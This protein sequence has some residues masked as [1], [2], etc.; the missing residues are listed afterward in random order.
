MKPNLAIFGGQKLQFWS[1][2][3]PLIM[4]FG[5]NATLESVKAA[6]FHTQL[7]C[8]FVTQPELS[9]VLWRK[10]K[11]ILGEKSAWFDLGSISGLPSGRSPFLPLYHPVST[12]V[13][14]IYEIRLHSFAKVC[15]LLQN[16]ANYFLCC[17]L[18]Y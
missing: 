12:K 16:I 1:F 10:T 14:K 17:T 7:L 11:T 18:E 13:C 8:F 9:A 3:R 6:G 4:I 5:E 2:W 15:K